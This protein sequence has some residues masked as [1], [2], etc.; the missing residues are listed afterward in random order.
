[1]PGTADPAASLR[2]ALRTYFDALYAAGLDPA[3][4]TDELAALIHPACACMR[5]VDVLRVQAKENRYVDYQYE[6]REITVLDATS[7]GGTVRYTVRQSAGALREASGRAIESY[8]AS[9][10]SY[11][12]H[13]VHAGDRWLLRRVDSFQ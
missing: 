6:L 7:A 2:G 10:E 13:F 11:S 5:A 9:T 8:P 3:D 4:K 12:A 1:V